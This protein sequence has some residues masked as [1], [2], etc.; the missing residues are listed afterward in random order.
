MEINEELMQTFGDQTASQD[1]MVL[2]EG[3]VEQILT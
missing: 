2:V 3:A 1:E